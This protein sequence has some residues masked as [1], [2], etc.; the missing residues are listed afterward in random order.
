MSTEC[1]M[2]AEDI[3]WIR[4]L[5]G[6]TVRKCTE[7]CFESFMSVGNNGLNGIRTECGM[8]CRIGCSVGV[9]KPGIHTWQ[10]SVQ[11]LLKTGSA[12]QNKLIIST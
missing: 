9:F 4:T 5:I 11:W 3:K 12:A 2:H 6:E 10:V 8:K 7:K 1:R